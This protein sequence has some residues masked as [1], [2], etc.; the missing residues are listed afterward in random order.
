MQMSR[1][2]SEKADFLFIFLWI[3]CVQILLQKIYHSVHHLIAPH[4]GLR[5][6]YS[7]DKTQLF[8]PSRWWL[9]QTSEKYPLV[10][11][12]NISVEGTEIVSSGS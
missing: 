9:R 3:Q 10:V 7:L 11:L 6:T 5:L 12:R 2:L 8:K 1:D 4:T